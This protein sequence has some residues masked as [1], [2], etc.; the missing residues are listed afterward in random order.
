MK[1]TRHS[2]TRAA[3]LAAAIL[4]AALP[5][6]ALLH[7]APGHAGDAHLIAT[8]APEFAHADSAPAPAAPS[9]IPQ[10]AIRIP[11]SAKPSRERRAAALAAYRQGRSIAIAQ[12]PAAHAQWRAAHEHTYF[13]D[14]VPELA[15]IAASADPGEGPAVAAQ[16]ARQYIASINRGKNPNLKETPPSPEI[17]GADAPALARL[18]ARDLWL[19]HY[20]TKAEC[21]AEP[22]DHKN[23]PLFSEAARRLADDTIRT[24]AYA[25]AL[26]KGCHGAGYNKW[27][28]GRVVATARSDLPA[29]RALVDAEI[30]G[31]VARQPQNR[32]LT[33]RLAE[34][35]AVR[36]ALK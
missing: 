12:G 9:V 15:A 8:T 19:A 23:L 1:T 25:R 17:E 2:H 36:N 18:H 11:H 10:S 32:V 34:L 31:L 21:A 30:L 26:G 28:A 27:F 7:A 3:A 22:A 33:D 29:A 35:R 14:A 16:I 5:A 13:A 4:A 6:P 20:A 24:D